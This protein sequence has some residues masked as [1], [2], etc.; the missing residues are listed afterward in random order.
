[1]HRKTIHSLLIL[2]TYAI[3]ALHAQQA[4]YSDV[5]LG[6]EML[7]AGKI[8]NTIHAWS[9]SETIGNNIQQST[10][11]T[12]HIFSAELVLMDEKK[13]LLGKV[14]VQDMNFQFADSCYYVFINYIHR[15]QESLIL[16]VDEEGNMFNVT[17]E[18]G[19]PGNE[20]IPQIFF[21][22][23]CLV[24]NNTSVFAAKTD[25]QSISRGLGINNATLID[26]DKLTPGNKLRGISIMKAMRSDGSLVSYTSYISSY[27]NFPYVALSATDSNLFSCAFTEPDMDASKKN[28]YKGSY[29]FLTKLDTNLLPINKQAKTLL[30]I[31]EGKKDETYSPQSIFTIDKK[32]LIVSIG[33]YGKIYYNNGTRF[34]ESY[35][36]SNIYSLLTTGTLRLTLF[37]EN[38]NLLKDTII[39]DKSMH[40]SFNPNNLFVSH[41]ANG[42]DIFFT[43][44]FSGLKNGIVQLSIN[45]DGSITDK[46]IIVDEDY[47][48]N[49]NGTIKPEAGVLLVPFTHKRTSGLMR[50]KYLQTE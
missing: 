45:K 30:K 8:G 38:N 47:S 33:R 22:P 2:I 42:A 3:P 25:I 4:R 50:V 39:D 18:P 13:I 19:I 14:S 11:L 1:M 41:T 44:K 29:M 48:Y 20:N 10:T 15:N 23:N 16:K 12:L 34:N 37:D 26:A 36:T 35:F 7:I 31:N 27:F 49:L 5:P 32:L 43:H 28:P 21:N 40:G 6:K 46:E 24:V 17:A 9:S